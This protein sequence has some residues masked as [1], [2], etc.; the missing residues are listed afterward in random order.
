MRLR[1]KLENKNDSTFLKNLTE[2]PGVYQMLDSTGCVLYV[3]KARNLKKR[4]SQYFKRTQDSLKTQALMS[5]VADVQVIITHTETEA[6]LLE[7]TLIKEKQPRYNVLMRDDKSYPYIFVS[8]DVYPRIEFH[9]G[10]R[11]EKGDYFGPFPSAVSVKET[12]HM[13]QQLFLIRPCSNTFFK[14]RSRP[15]LQYQ[16]GR[17]S[18]PCVSL[19]SKEQ[20][21]E[22]VKHAV[23]FL[24]GKDSDI[25][26]ALGKRMDEASSKL[27]YEE[28]ALYR[29]KIVR[30]RHI[31]EQQCV[32]H[33]EGDA[34]VFALARESHMVCIHLFSIRRGRLKVNKNF[35]PKLPKNAED[36]DILNT[37]VSQY[38]LISEHQHS[39]PSRII[40]SLALEDQIILSVLLSE[41]QGKK[42][43]VGHRV[44][45]QRAAWLRLALT[46]A[47]EALRSALSEQEYY[48]KQLEALRTV[49][50]LPNVPLRIECFDISHTSGE[51]TVASCVVFDSEG[52]KKSD[53]RRF[54]IQGIAS[55]DDYAAMHSVLE[56]RYKKIKEDEAKR[57]DIILIDGGKGQLKVAKTVTTALGLLQC[58]LLAISKGKG[59]KPGL[60]TLHTL[61]RRDFTLPA[62][63]PALHLLQ[64][65]RD[66]AH[67]FAITGHRQQRGRARKTSSLESIPG[68]GIVKRRALLRHFGGIQGITS[69]GITDLQ[70]V[71]GISAEL[72]QVIYDAFHT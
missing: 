29:D 30:L 47:K 9:R 51:N 67:R 11:R 57:P 45:G 41:K 33:Q 24:Q 35:F 42:I 16:I 60:E 58:L 56:R 65:I 39:I 62:D 64:H 22:D 43:N 59:R 3:G 10:H 63:S 49:L 8:G 14:N 72:A 71:P 2:R 55:G 70:K 6:L 54:N 68:I 46:N 48:K 7:C 37:F 36:H 21:A 19:I 12:L 38:Y 32:T 23:L 4:V 28:A 17:C 26:D 69:A 15:C 44:T 13:L 25:I 66:E 34:D 1:R 52:A 20:Y 18:A 40:T 61:V 5:H 27:Q 50:D 31:Q 53:Y